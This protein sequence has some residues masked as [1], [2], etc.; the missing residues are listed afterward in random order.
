[1][2][3]P[4]HGMP[5]LGKRVVYHDSIH[6][7]ATLYYIYVQSICFFSVLFPCEKNEMFLEFFPG[8]TGEQHEF[9]GEKLK[10]L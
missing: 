5:A 4:Q 2:H 8:K 10:E 9:G 1:M 3:P 7:E 6:R